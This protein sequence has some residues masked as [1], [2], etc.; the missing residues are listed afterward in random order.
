MAE[1][2]GAQVGKFRELA[3]EWDAD[4]DE[5]KFEDQVRRIAPKAPQPKAEKSDD[6]GS[7][8]PRPLSDG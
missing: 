4:E 2:A 6:Q 3:R 1:R 8:S 5:A 7:G